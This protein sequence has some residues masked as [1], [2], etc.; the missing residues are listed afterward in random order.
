MK[1]GYGKYNQI[2]IVTTSMVE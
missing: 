2:T 1:T